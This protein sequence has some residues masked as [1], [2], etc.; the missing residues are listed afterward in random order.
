MNRKH[1]GGE[2]DHM[3]CM[4]VWTVG[5]L[6]NTFH[7]VAPFS[8]RTGKR[9]MEKEPEKSRKHNHHCPDASD[10]YRASE[11]MNLRRTKNK[12]PRYGRVC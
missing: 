9:A 12:N 11:N 7:L 8:W 1:L 3:L 6:E 5:V 2:S 10:G 4:W